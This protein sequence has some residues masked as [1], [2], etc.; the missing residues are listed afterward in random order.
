MA[1]TAAER[2]REYRSRKRDGV[3]NDTVTGVTKTVTGVTKT[4]TGVT[5]TVTGVT[6]TVTDTVTGVT[7]TVTKTV[8]GVT[9]TVTDTVTEPT[10]TVT[11]TQGGNATLL[12][13]DVLAS[14]EKDC[15]ENNGGARDASHSRAAMTERALHYQRVCGKPQPKPT[16]VCQTCGGP[17]Q[18][19]LIVKCFQC[20]HGKP[21]PAAGQKTEAEAEGPLS[22]YSEARWAFLQSQGHTWDDST[23]RSYRIGPQGTLIKG[24]TVPGDP[25]YVG[26]SEAVRQ[27]LGEGA[28]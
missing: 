9:D 1:Q 26:H 21:A 13:T 14:I 24:V 7:D 19:P 8:T 5:K 18:H 23:Q 20:V 10:V 28:A 25:A 2:S 22:V 15:A 16:G 27:V 6:D 17:V 11:V 3:T 4:V 12:P